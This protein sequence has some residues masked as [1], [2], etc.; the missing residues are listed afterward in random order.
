MNGFFTRL[1]QRTLGTAK[2]AQPSITPRF[3]Q[4]TW[5]AEDFHF[6]GSTEDRSHES[7][8]IANENLM[9]E[10]QTP[11]SEP[12]RRKQQPDNPHPSQQERM[13][14]R[15]EQPSE[16]TN[17]AKPR[18]V[19]SKKTIDPVRP[20]EDI[21]NNT[22][23]P[24]FSE[25][26]QTQKVPYNGPKQ[27]ILPNS[28]QDQSIEEAP[29]VPIALVRT[30][31]MVNSNTHAENSAYTTGVPFLPGIDGRGNS[32]RS[33]KNSS[34]ESQ[35]IKVTIGRI[36][37]RAVYP[38]PKPVKLDRA[39]PQPALSLDDYLQQRRKGER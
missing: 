31:G 30:Q 20:L 4:E 37:V 11:A 18:K 24:D 23:A 32:N 28:G 15:N 35:T 17:I 9:P 2:T 6:S 10:M 33:E 16:Y 38:P 8:G 19:D 27:L 5:I 7:N 26:R 29:L 13:S 25:D 3:A 22:E 21:K 39:K 12:Q 34:D 14:E 36:D 1:A